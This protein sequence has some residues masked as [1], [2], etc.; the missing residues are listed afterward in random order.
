MKALHRVVQ[1]I[2]K[3]AG[4]F[5]D[6][7]L[8]SRGGRCISFGHCAVNFLCGGFT[9]SGGAAGCEPQHQ[10]RRDTAGLYA[11]WRTFF[12]WRASCG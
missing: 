11:L 3:A 1:G 12:V 5:D 8:T 10:K 7:R 6:S 4:T 2:F 9:I